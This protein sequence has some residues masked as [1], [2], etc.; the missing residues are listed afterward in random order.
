[1]EEEQENSEDKALEIAFVAKYVLEHNPVAVSLKG[2]LFRLD[3]RANLSVFNLNIRMVLRELAQ[4]AQILQ[5][6][7]SLAVVDQ[8]ARGLR[9]PGNH[10]NEETTGDK[11]DAH[12][13]LPLRVVVLYSWFIPQRDTIVYPEGE[14]E[15]GDDHQVVRRRHGSTNRFGRVLG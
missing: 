13:S 6:L 8:V 12:G 5:T 9:D 3:L 1:M 4:P 11:L 10:Q 15:G 7:L 14:H 2:L